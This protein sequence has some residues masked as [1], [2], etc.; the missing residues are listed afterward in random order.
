VYGGVRYDSTLRTVHGTRYPD[1]C[2]TVRRYVR[3]TVQ[4]ASTGQNVLGRLD[5]CTVAIL[6]PKLSDPRGQKILGQLDAVR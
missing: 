5:D 3:T 4:A 1:D 6:S 2:C